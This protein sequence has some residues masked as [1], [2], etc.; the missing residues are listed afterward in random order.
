MPYF[1]SYFEII[2][3]N[4]FSAFPNLAVLDYNILLSTYLYLYNSK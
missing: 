4:D 2:W 1:F 3:L